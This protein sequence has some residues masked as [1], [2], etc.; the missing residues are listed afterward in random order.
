MSIDSACLLDFKQN[1]TS[2]RVVGACMGAR[3]SRSL[4]EYV[5][6]CQTAGSMTRTYDFAEPAITTPVLSA[7]RDDPDHRA[8]QAASAADGSKLPT[9]CDLR[10]DGVWPLAQGCDNSVVTSAAC[11]VANYAA[12]LSRSSFAEPLSRLFLSYNAEAIRPGGS[13][14]TRSL[15]KALQRHGLCR[16]VD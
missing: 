4:M 13:S 14:S 9:I 16:E 6:F 10:Q 7:A 11:A 1:P 8:L 2:S 15:L 3:S 5:L 12:S